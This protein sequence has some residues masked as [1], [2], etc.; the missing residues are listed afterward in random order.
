MH[1][2][3]FHTRHKGSVYFDPE[4]IDTACWLCHHRVPRSDHA[5][6]RLRRSKGAERE[7]MLLRRAETICAPDMDSI[8]HWASVRLRQYEQ[9]EI[10]DSDCRGSEFMQQQLQGA[11]FR[12]RAMATG[13]QYFDEQTGQLFLLTPGDERV[14][15]D[16]A[17]GLLLCYWQ[18]KRFH[19]EPV[20]D[21]GI[22]YYTI[23]SQPVAVPF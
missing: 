6:H 23:G 14:L 22:P 7:E 19:W 10:F 15:V 13:L 4:N 9:G 18:G 17:Y 5:E 8:A 20:T 12:A 3:H 21:Y 1:A 2:A 11:L 16:R